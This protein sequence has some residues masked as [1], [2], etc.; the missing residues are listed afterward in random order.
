MFTG[1]NF[2]A[3]IGLA[4]PALAAEHTTPVFDQLMKQH[5]LMSDMFA[6]YFTTLAEDLGPAN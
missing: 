1:D 2:E 6:F 5:L 3:I 4:Y